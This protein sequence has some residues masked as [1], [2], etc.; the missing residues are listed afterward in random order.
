MSPA[1]TALYADQLLLLDVPAPWPKPIRD[2]PRLVGMMDVVGDLAVPTRLLGATPIDDRIRLTVFRNVNGI[3][4]R[5]THVIDGD[6]AIP[7]AIA[8]VAVGEETSRA[9]RI[10]EPAIRKSL[11]VCTQGSHDVCCGSDGVRL[12]AEVE[13]RMPDIDV[14]RVSHTGGHRF[15]PTAMTF[16]DGRMWAWLD[17]AD[18][19]RIMERHGDHE[20]LADRCRGWWGAKRG[21]QQTAEVALFAATGWSLDSTDRSVEADGS[22]VVVTA[23]GRRTPFEVTAVRTVPTIS[24]RIAGG[25]P[26]KDATEY[27]ASRR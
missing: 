13:R 12:A 11:L 9:V 14:Y 16:P 24:C 15:A 8:A 22:R 2:H 19:E 20:D 18:V 25:L 26:T 3:G 17:L 4:M 6:D 7:Q 21:P 27:E 23:D 1:G 5:S 10:E